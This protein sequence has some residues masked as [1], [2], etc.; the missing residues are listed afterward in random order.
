MRKILLALLIV[1]LALPKV[2]FAEKDNLEKNILTQRETVITEEKAESEPEPIVGTEKILSEPR[3]TIYQMAQWASQE[4]YKADPDFIGLA[5]LFYQISREYGVDPAVIYAQSAKETNF[6]RYTGVVPKSFYNTC[7]LKTTEGG[8]NDDILAHAKFPSWEVGITAQVHHLALY[9]GHEDFPM[10]DSP[11]PRHFSWI[12]G[13]APHVEELGGRWAPSRTYGYEILEM[14]EAIQTFPASP[15]KPTVNR[16]AGSN[17]YKTSEKINQFLNT[18]SRTAV[19]SSGASFSDSSTATTLAKSTD[20]T[21]YL[22]PP[23]KTTAEF[24]K[25]IVNKEINRVYIVGGTRALGTHIESLLKKNRIT[26]ERIGGKNRYETANLIVKKINEFNIKEGIDSQKKVAVL[27]TGENFA[28]AI[29]I[30]PVAV[31]RNY[32]I[33]LTRSKKIPDSTFDKLKSYKEVLI[34]GGTDAVSSDIEKHLIDAG[35]KIER[36][37]GE[38]RYETS[39]K[40]AKEFYPLNLSV[41]FATGRDFPDSLAAVVLA[42]QNGGPIVLTNSTLDKKLRGYLMDSKPSKTFIIGGEAAVTTQFEKDLIRIS[43]K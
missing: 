23:N 38:N 18:K 37:S 19:V 33:F 26:H 25:A 7:G 42:D 21:L 4:K 40:I 32:P 2:S 28:D 17:R 6:M 22:V 39:F 35:L 36:I 1:M 31:Q 34:V 27:T 15:K 16:L 14:I 29:S 12:H 8:G 3:A 20:S 41:T 43:Y 11:D 9:A 24:E 10:K 13:V 30:S 5:P